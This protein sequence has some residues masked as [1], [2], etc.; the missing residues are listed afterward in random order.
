[1]P[2]YEVEYKYLLSRLN[3]VTSNIEPLLLS[4]DFTQLQ[5][6]LKTCVDQKNTEI[7]VLKREKNEQANEITDFK[8]EIKNLEH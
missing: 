2:A 3:L 8:K 6:K 1:M 5:T 7:E 4:I